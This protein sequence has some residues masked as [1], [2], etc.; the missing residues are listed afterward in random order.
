[1]TIIRRPALVVVL[2]ASLLVSACGGSATPSAPPAS[3]APASAAATATPAPTPTATPAPTPSP[4]PTVAPTPTPAPSADLG[5]FAF[6]PEQIIGY[7]LGLGFKCGTAAPLAQAPGYSIVRCEKTKK[8]QPTAMVTLAWTTD[9]KV[10]GY[11]F[12]GYFN[13]GKGSK[14]PAKDEAFVHL[15]G[16]IGALLGQDDGTVVAS[17]VNDNFGTKVNDTYNGMAIF[18]YPQK[19]ASSNGF[20]V[21]IANA[22]FQAAIGQ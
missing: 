2:G 13:T 12:A 9:G 17:W 5:G 4:A 3:V 14:L 19:D 7:Y 21:E 20:Y 11:G 1:M 10:T 16:F 18:H 6:P 15:G 22:D 8:K